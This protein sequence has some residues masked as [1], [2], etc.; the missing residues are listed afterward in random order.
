MAELWQRLKDQRFD[1]QSAAA[2]LLAER[3]VLRTGLSETE[4]ADILFVLSDADVF[5]AYVQDRGWSP[6]Q[7][8]QWLGNTF[9][10]LLLR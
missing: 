9:C 7:V 1:G 3:Q 10:A 2:H 4:A 5:A 6:A 8:A